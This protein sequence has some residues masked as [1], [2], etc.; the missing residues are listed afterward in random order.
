MDLSQEYYPNGQ[1]EMKDVKKKHSSSSDSSIEKENDWIVDYITYL[2]SFV[3][4]L[5]NGTSMKMRNFLV[6]Y[7]F[8][9]LW[10]RNTV[11]SSA[12]KNYSMKTTN[13]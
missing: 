10:L 6:K 11:C 3:S 12:E 5:L 13:S 8:K 9:W 7:Q 4:T 2:Y 1:I